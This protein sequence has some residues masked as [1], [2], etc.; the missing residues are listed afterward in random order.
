M[1]LDIF[2]LHDYLTIVIVREGKYHGPEKSRETKEDKDPP[3]TEG[4][5]QQPEIGQE[6]RT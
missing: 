4:I 6:I 3:K 5:L 1:S 2:L